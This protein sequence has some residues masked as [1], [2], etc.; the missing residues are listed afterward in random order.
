MEK[1]VLIIGDLHISDRFS[2]KHKDYL[3]N[4]FD[5]LDMIEKSII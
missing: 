2:G 5:C 4:C 1:K 3:Q